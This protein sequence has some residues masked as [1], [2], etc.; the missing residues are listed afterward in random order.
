M[1]F[2]TERAAEYI[3][4]FP[5]PAGQHFPYTESIMWPFLKG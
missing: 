1:R 3:L 4:I 2:F 5:V